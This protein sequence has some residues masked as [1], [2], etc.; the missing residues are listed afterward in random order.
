MKDKR[1]G[2]IFMDKISKN[3]LDRMPKIIKSSS[4]ETV[5]KDDK[6]IIINSL[7][8][9]INYGK[10]G[11][12]ISNKN[13]IP[14]LIMPHVKKEKDGER[15]IKNDVVLVSGCHSGAGKLIAEYLKKQIVV[16]IPTTKKSR[17][18]GKKRKKW[19]SPYT[20]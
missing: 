15:Y 9:V 2:V 20:F 18:K 13:N 16:D 3:I 11:F 1:K 19:E 8:N 10:I 12:N 17:G 5:N 6:I 4:D 7:S 14:I